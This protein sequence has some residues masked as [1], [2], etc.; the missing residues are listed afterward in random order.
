VPILTVIAG[1]NGCGK[2]TITRNVTIEGLD[3]LLDPDAIAR[4]LNPTNPSSAA[5]AAGREV[6]KRTARYFSEGV[7]FVIETTLSGRGRLELLRDAKA[8]GF[9][10]HLVFVALDDPNR[11][12]RRI[13]NR[14]RLGGH[15]VPDEDV[16]RRYERSIAN[17]A[18][19]LRE[20]HMARFYDN[21]GDHHR[22]VLIANCGTIVW[23]A[24]PLPNW[25]KL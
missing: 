13:Q 10:V 15:F 5:V 25:L 8:R 23:Q 1:P 6:L 3:R 24:D 12:I 18:T 22:L 17:A 9:E 4:D 16:K 21:S 7:N 11:C 20:V 14:V 19:A 2:S